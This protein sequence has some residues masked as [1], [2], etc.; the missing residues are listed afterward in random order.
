MNNEL[1]H[2]RNIAYMISMAMYIRT[3]TKIQF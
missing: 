1:E 3:A 2:I